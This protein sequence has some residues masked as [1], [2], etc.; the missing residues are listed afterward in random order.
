MTRLRSGIERSI[1]MP[2]RA[3][4]LPAST[5]AIVIS[6]I[7]SRSQLEISLS[8]H[9]RSHESAED[10]DAG[11]FRHSERSE[12]S[13]IVLSP[14]ALARG[15][16]GRNFMHARDTIPQWG[17]FLSPDR[18]TGTPAR[19]Q[20]WNRYAY[21]LNNP[22]KYTDPS[23]D[24][25]EWAPGSGDADKKFIRSAMIAAIRTAQGRGGFLSIANDS[26]AVVLNVRGPQ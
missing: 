17:R 13:P 22:L 8:R 26:R 25:F 15:L 20:T 7:A 24:Y 2:T 1:A 9:S 19:P 4:A 11:S 6:G 18:L 16:E 21:A 3:G 12:E 5:A 14:R 23:G 10:H